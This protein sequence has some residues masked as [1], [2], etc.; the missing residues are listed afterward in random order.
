M[1]FEPTT[2]GSTDGTRP[3]EEHSFSRLRGASRV[4]WGYSGAIVQ[5]IVQLVGK[6]TVC[7]QILFGLQRTSGFQI[8]SSPNCLEHLFLSD[9]GLLQHLRAFTRFP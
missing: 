4:L 9:S 1:G 2:L 5:P 3:P 7:S 6:G 8:T